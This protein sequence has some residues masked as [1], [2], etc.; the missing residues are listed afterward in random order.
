MR[1]AV[2]TDLHANR[3]ATEAVLAAVGPLAPDRTMILGDVVGY[4]PDPVWAVETVAGLVVKGATCLMGN[5]D[6]AAVAGGGDMVSAAE[7]AIRWTRTRLS[8]DHLAFLAG[9]PLTAE[10]GDLLFVHASAARPEAWDYVLDVDTAD[11]CL[12]ATTARTVVCGHTHRPALFYALGERRPVHYRPIDNEPAPLSALR[13]HVAVVGAVGQP[14]DG[15][16]AACFGL[17]DTAAGTITMVRVPY[18]HGTTARKIR[19]AGLPERLA[20]RLAGGR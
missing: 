3:E 11:R 16:P 15:N 5:H 13:R 17:M 14:R 12:R 18:D 19:E 8:P 10:A 6:E 20:G 9:L 1:I 4:G 2:L 7:E